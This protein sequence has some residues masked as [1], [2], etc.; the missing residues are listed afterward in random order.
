MFENE[1]YVP[2]RGWGHTW[3]GHFL[4]TD[5]VGH[6][7]LRGDRTDGPDGAE[8]N[9]IAPDVKEVRPVTPCASTRSTC[10][11]RSRLC[12]GIRWDFA[13]HVYRIVRR[14]SFAC[15]RGSC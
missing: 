4:P 14:T 3:P 12:W 1:R 9:A 11:G 10:C 2:F 15:H 7:S 5:R 8:F 13:E 6:W